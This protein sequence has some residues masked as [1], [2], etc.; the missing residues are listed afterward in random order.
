MSVNLPLN[1]KN[2]SKKVG[3]LLLRNFNLLKLKVQCMASNI[4]YQVALASK[5]NFEALELLC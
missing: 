1:Q 2:L 3:I 4:T 5:I